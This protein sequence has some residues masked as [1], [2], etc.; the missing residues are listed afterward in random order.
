MSR[1]QGLSR[2]R[3]LAH[4]G[5]RVRADLISFWEG[6]MLERGVFSAG[7]R[8]ESGLWVSKYPAWS[9]SVFCLGCKA[10]AVE[11]MFMFIFLFIFNVELKILQEANIY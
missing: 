1:V 8:L 9:Q 6:Q 3:E 11:I 5:V 2:F 7:I 10:P 4:G